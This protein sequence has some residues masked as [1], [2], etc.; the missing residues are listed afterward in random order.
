MADLFS[1]DGKHAVITGGLGLIGLELVGAMLDYGARVTILDNGSSTK[2]PTDVEL[3]Q[4]DLA[5]AGLI[6]GIAAD[7]DASRGPVDIL[8]NNASSRGSQGKFFASVEDY[9][10]TTWAE[11]MDVNL[12]APFWTSC[13]FGSRM[14][15]RGMGSII[16]TSS[17]YASDM[18]VDHRIYPAA[19]R[20]S[21]RMNAP[22]SYA[23]SKAGLVGLTRY[24]A[25]YWAV[26]G[27]RVN[28]IAPG[29]VEAGQPESFRAAYSA[30]VPMGRMAHSED[31]VG[32]YIFLASDAAS[33]VTGQVIYVDGGLS[34]W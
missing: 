34:S 24:L 4:C 22:A 11:V 25:T 28:A 15:L 12:G 5:D 7:V 21:D 14:A 33:Y 30:R 20:H 29:G 6:P 8:I 19:K 26:S 3:I 13:A 31:L 10:P 18:G 9:D 23:A 2:T 32:A 17:I 16:N 27:V 1:L